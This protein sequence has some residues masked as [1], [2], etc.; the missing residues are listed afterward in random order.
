MSTLRPARTSLLAAAVIIF[1]F[2]FL[3]VT[4][5]TGIPLLNAI[6]GELF[7]WLMLLGGVAMLLGIINV[8]WLHG[9]RIQSGQRDWLLSL[10][11]IGVMLGVFVSGVIG[12]WVS[13][14]PLLDLAFLSVV[15]PAQAALFALL[16]FFMAA[17]AFR[18]LRVSRT[19]G[20]WMLIGAI[21]V[22]LVELPLSYE[23]LPPGMVQATFWIVDTP[24]MAALRGA[25]IG[26]GIAMLV[27]VI[28]M[29]AGRT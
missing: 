21:L 12:S 5:I 29:L 9:K 3:V 24:V 28:R 18:Y 23:W 15:A 16:V 7:Q 26:S 14:S 13:Q 6:A 22:L 19:G 11:L 17:A 4:R 1:L 25:L 8:V 10:I 20:G 27:V 2:I